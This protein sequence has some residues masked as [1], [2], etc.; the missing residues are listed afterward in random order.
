MAKREL[1]YAELPK[2]L[3][4]AE[5]ILRRYGRWAKDRTRPQRCGSAE[6]NYKAAPN[7]DDRLPVEVLMH[8]SDVDSVRAALKDMQ[9]VNRM[10][11]MWIYVPDREPIQAKMRRC[12]I[13]PRV[14]RE[15]H[16]EGVGEFWKYWMKE[17][18]C[19]KKQT[20]DKHSGLMYCLAT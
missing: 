12:G 19:M 7:D 3:Q 5:E 9:P 17:Q 13:P 16:L 4:D 15:R 11:L 6:G 1:L 20:V 18:H 2:E 10:V 8:P 14:M